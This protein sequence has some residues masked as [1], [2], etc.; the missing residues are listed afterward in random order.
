MKQPVLLTIFVIGLLFVNACAVHQKSDTVTPIT[1]KEGI[2]HARK[3]TP[4]QVEV[5]KQKNT[6]KIPKMETHMVSNIKNPDD[7]SKLQ[8]KVEGYVIAAMT[9]SGQRYNAFV[10]TEPFC[11]YDPEG[12]SASPFILMNCE[13]QPISRSIM[14]MG[15]S[16]SASTQILLKENEVF[17][18]KLNKDKESWAGLQTPPIACFTPDKKFIQCPELTAIPVDNSTFFIVTIDKDGNTTLIGNGKTTVLKKG[19][20]VN[21]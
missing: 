14:M 13:D 15:K 17:T 19:I 1:Q 5:A 18:M 4:Q 20:I 10:E 8:Y 21:K 7:I 12:D 2:G 3:P 9:C 11:F 6:V 16:Q